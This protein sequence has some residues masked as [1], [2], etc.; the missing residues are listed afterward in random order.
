MGGTEHPAGP[1][2]GVPFTSSSVYTWIKHVYNFNVVKASGPNGFNLKVFRL[3]YPWT[4]DIYVCYH[5]NGS[6]LIAPENTQNGGLWFHWMPKQGDWVVDEYDY[7]TGS[8]DAADGI[9]NDYRNGIAAWPTSSRFLMRT[10]ARPQPYQILFFDQV[11]NN[12]VATG[13][14]QYIDSI[15]VDDSRQR[16][17]LSTEAK[18][19]TQVNFGTESDR[20][21]QIPVSWTDSQIQ[22]MARQGSLD[23]LAASICM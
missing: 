21:I 20:E 12:E 2:N 1:Q 18:W 19:S 13:T 3:W 11:S 22:I 8:V 6:S 9:L 10:S 16:V 15:Y 7:Q 17:I 14:Y 4:H 5:G 23:S